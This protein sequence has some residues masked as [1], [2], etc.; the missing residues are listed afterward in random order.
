MTTNDLRFLIAKHMNTNLDGLPANSV[1]RVDCVDGDYFEITSTKPLEKRYHND[2][3]EFTDYMINHYDRKGTFMAG[4][5]VQNSFHLA[6]AKMFIHASDW[7]I[8][9]I[10][11]TRRVK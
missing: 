6:Q 11:F 7:G 10:R 9:G 3:L 8:A 1:Y 2:Y 4:E 5:K